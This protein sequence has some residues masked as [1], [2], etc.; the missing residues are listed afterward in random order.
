[1]LSPFK[2]RKI[3]SQV[4]AVH[5]LAL[6]C[7]LDAVDRGSI[8]IASGHIR[9]ARQV[10]G[11]DMQIVGVGAVM[12]QAQVIPGGERQWILNHRIDLWMLNEIY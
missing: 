9:V 11:R 8:Q 6:V 2:I 7:I 10:N 3:L 5:R 12:E 1:V 4:R